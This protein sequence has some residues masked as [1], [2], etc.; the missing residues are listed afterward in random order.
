[1]SLRAPAQ[2]GQG[3]VSALVEAKRLLGQATA[4]DATSSYAQSL[5]AFAE[6][7]GALAG[8]TRDLAGMLGEPLS[9]ADGGSSRRGRLAGPR[10]AGH[11]S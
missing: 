7:Q 5:S 2:I 11:L 6:F 9:A 1:M 3:S 8:W 4:L 10:P